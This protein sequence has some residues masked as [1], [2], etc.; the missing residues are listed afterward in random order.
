[1]LWLRG[2]K[3]PAVALLCAFQ[4]NILFPIQQLFSGCFSQ[5][6][7]W[8]PCSYLMPDQRDCP[9]QNHPAGAQSNFPALSS[10]EVK[11]VFGRGQERVGLPT[12]W[13]PACDGAHENPSLDRGWLWEHQGPAMGASCWA[14][15]CCSQLPLFQCSSGL[16]CVCP[17]AH[18]PRAS[19]TA[20]SFTP[21]AP[22][23]AHIHPDLFASQRGGQS[24]PPSG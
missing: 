8:L 1:M 20:S 18:Y 19:P 2:G 12:P 15:H 4:I 9:A 24:R 14:S 3:H 23:Y 6:S 13:Q 21:S 22:Q 7:R 10:P 17:T 16:F 11:N 5:R